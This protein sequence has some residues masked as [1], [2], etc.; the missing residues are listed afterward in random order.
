MVP[1]LEK[2]GGCGR[3]IGKIPQAASKT[4][5]EFHPLGPGFGRAARPQQ[6]GRK[7]FLARSFGPFLQ[8]TTNKP[9]KARN[10]NRFKF[11]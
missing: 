11:V 3:T 4:G 8:Q 9:K 5:G 1:V 2:L 7:F 10:I 6:L